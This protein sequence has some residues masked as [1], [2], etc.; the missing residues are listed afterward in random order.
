[1][2]LPQLGVRQQQLPQGEAAVPARGPVPGEGDGRVPAMQKDV[3][4]AQSAR[5]ELLAG[6]LPGATLQVSKMGWIGQATK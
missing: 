3:V 1:M 5:Q 2:Q 6:R 4:P